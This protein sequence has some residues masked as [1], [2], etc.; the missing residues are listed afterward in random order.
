MNAIDTNIL[1]YAFDTAYPEKRIVCHNLIK[2]VFDGVESAV[3]TNQILVEFVWAVTKKIDKPLSQQEARAIV[4]AIMTS[5]NWKIFNYSANT[6]LNALELKQPFW[7]ALITQTLKE[8]NVSTIIT[9]NTK[10]FAHSGIV[11]KNPF[12]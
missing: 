2:K 4:G 9:E 11:A 6:I 3:V 5:E 10:D 7:D 12:G 1:V 8:N